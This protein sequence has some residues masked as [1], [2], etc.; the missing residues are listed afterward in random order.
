MI[1]QFVDSF[2]TIVDIKKAEARHREHFPSQKSAVDSKKRP[3]MDN[4]VPDRAKVHKPYVG[5]T[6]AAVLSGPP[7][8]NNGQAQWNSF[9]PQTTYVQQTQGWQQPTLQQP[10]PPVQQQQWNQG[11]SAHQVEL[12]LSAF[13]YAQRRR[14][15]SCTCWGTSCS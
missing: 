2:G 4:A 3:S 12:S 7:A 11:Y 15:L 14:M 8:Y 1:V 6:A 13:G 10:A 5:A 9:A